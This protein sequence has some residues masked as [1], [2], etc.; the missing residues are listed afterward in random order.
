[1][2][3]KNFV[4]D[5]GVAAKGEG[6]SLFENESSNIGFSTTENVPSFR[7]DPDEKPSLLVDESDDISELEQKPTIRRKQKK[8]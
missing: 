8:D 3:D 7:F 1:M 4:Y 2:V 6:I 5:P